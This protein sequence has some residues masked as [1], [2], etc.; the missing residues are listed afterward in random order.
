[1]KMP[2]ELCEKRYEHHSTTDNTADAVGIQILDEV[3]K[4][5]I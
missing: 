2:R 4:L 1:M 5:G 3:Y